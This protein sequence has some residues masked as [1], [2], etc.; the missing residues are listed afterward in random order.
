MR[1]RCQQVYLQGRQ[2]PYRTDGQGMYCRWHRILHDFRR[3]LQKMP[4]IAHFYM[5]GV[6]TSLAML[7]F[8]QWKSLQVP[9]LIWLL[10]SVWS[11][12]W[13]L[14]LFSDAIIAKNFPLSQFAIWGKLLAYGLGGAILS[15]AV[16]IAYISADP[17]AA[18]PL[19][20]LLADR[21]SW[22]D[23]RVLVAVATVAI[24]PNVKMLLERILFLRFKYTGTVL[25]L[26]SLW[27]ATWALRPRILELVGHTPESSGNF[28]ADVLGENY[29]WPLGIAYIV[30]FLLCE[31]LN[32]RMRVSRCDES[33]FKATVWPSFPVC[34]GTPLLALVFGRYA[35]A[36]T[37]WSSS[38]L[39]VVLAVGVSIPICLYGSS[40]IVRQAQP[41]R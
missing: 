36:L 25:W 4:W 6:Y 40:M 14:I 29:K 7:V 31:H 38:T 26:G 32:V 9:H 35:L 13:A 12:C 41:S 34:A 1:I 8:F 39:F 11:I 24:V 33:T 3:D 21:I 22:L 28:W 15:G 18:K 30:S 23:S 19:L 10:L 5:Y 27:V 37:G 20:D 2:C 16:V 17:S